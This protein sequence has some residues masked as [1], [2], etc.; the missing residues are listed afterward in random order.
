[1]HR[2]YQTKTQAKADIFE[3]TEVFY[4]RSRRHSS[5]GYMNPEQYEVIK[6]AA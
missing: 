5:L 4:N 3:Y 1:M 2:D 6:M